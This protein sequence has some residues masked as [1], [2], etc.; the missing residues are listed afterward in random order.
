MK[1]ITSLSSLQ[2]LSLFVGF[3]SFSLTSLR[4]LFHSD[5]PLLHFGFRVEIKSKTE[6]Q[7][8]TDK[9]H[10][11]TVVVW[12][13]KTFQSRCAA[14]LQLNSENSHRQLNHNLHEAQFNH[15]FLPFYYLSLS[16]CS[17]V[18]LRSDFNGEA[19]REKTKKKRRGIRFM[20]VQRRRRQ[21]ILSSQKS[22]N[23]H[24][25]YMCVF[26]LYSTDIP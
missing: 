5:V 13:M 18:V 26:V 2:F 11:G 23:E 21:R 16:L 3:A 7:K 17:L 9:F 20:C 15:F 1:R 22:T 25:T 6:N 14:A 12:S 19:N 10:C 24:D 4:T 8:S